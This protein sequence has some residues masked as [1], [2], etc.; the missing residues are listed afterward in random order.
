MARHIEPDVGQRVLVA[1]GPPSV[2]CA[3]S[4]RFSTPA[5]ARGR[6]RSSAH[7]TRKRPP[8]PPVEVLLKIKETATVQS[9]RVHRPW[10]WEVETP[11]PPGQ[12]QYFEIPDR[13]PC[14]SI[15]GRPHR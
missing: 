4:G 12:V 8:V 11:T 3:G 5:A 14:I 7:S 10:I 2:V 15:L 1:K 13:P 9:V 6:P